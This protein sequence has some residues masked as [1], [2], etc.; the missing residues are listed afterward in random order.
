MSEV[1]DEPSDVFRDPVNLESQRLPCSA[2][3]LAVQL[4]ERSLDSA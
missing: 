3:V 4:E 2:E 1:L